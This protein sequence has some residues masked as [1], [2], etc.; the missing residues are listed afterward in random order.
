M[1]TA[2][3]LLA[4]LLVEGHEH[5]VVD[6][7]TRFV[8]DPHT[9]VISHANPDEL[10][11]MQ[12]DH[13]SERFT[14]ELP[15]YIDG[16]DM[17]LCNQVYVHFN[18]IDISGEITYSDV[19]EITDLQI[20]KDDSSKVICSWLLTRYATQYAGKLG[21]IVEFACVIP[22]TD[23]EGPQTTYEWHTDIFGDVTVKGSLDNAKVLDKKEYINILHQ[24][25][26]L[27]WD[28]KNSIITEL[29]EYYE[30]SVMD[31][32]Q[33]VSDTIS[34]I[35]AKGQAT[36]ETIPDDYTETY[37]NARKA[38]RTRANAIVNTAEG[39]VISVNDASDDYLRGL[40]IFGKSTQESDPS[41][42]N[43]QQIESVKNLTL[44]MTGANL[45]DFNGITDT[46]D[47]KRNVDGSLTVTIYSAPTGYTLKQLA[48]T[49]KA[50]N[51][52]T[53]YIDTDSSNKLIYFLN[54][55]TTWSS[56]YTGDM[57]DAFLNDKVC[58]YGVNGDAPIIIRNIAIVP[59]GVTYNGEP[60]V[61]PQTLTISHT[62][63]GIPVDS[64]GNY[65][66]ENGQQWIC[67]EIDFERGKYVQRISEMVCKGEESEYWSHNENIGVQKTGFFTLTLSKLNT[68]R[69]STDRAIMCD[70]YKAS[71]KLPISNHEYW[72]KD[73]YFGIKQVAFRNDNF[74]DLIAW[75]AN[76]ASNPITVIYELATPIYHDLTESEL[77]A[78][79]A[80]HSNYPTT[81]FMNDQGAHM[82][83]KYNADTQTVFE[84]SFRPT[85]AQVRAAVDAWLTA[86]F[87]S[88]EGV[89][90]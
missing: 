90:F 83:L 11:V 22:S 41:P 3:E 71:A 12:G 75:K 88:A 2:S 52:Y 61:N 27:L 55:K 51:R 33:L 64:G 50:G 36:L 56:G 42:D 34:S 86:H 37:N 15:R 69:E 13:N 40:R 57:T 18:N 23:T 49:L 74:S 87:S 78:Y 35:E 19:D 5:P 62:L 73:T 80:L 32:Q 38:L 82:E 60:Y 63:P 54:S 39:S 53:I 48:P 70:S 77:A 59:E 31:A 46:N 20:D 25:R 21:F 66:D 1:A 47:I 26:E 4:D 28:S 79:S 81:T 8:I 7:E 10:F 30:G 14:F 67:D 72:A 58:L 16:H 76:L 85:D 43:P 17:M 9:R 89:K 24:W 29:G 44:D 68:T 84:N 65:T 6:S 45:F